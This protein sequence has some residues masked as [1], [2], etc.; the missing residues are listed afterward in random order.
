MKR[1][2]YVIYIHLIHYKTGDVDY[3]NWKCPVG[4]GGRYKHVPATFFQLLDFIE[5]GPLEIPAYQT[6]TEEIQKWHIP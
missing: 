1:N 5:L 6:C 4:A 3:V 2:N